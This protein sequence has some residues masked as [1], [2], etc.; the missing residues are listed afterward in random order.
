MNGAGGQVAKVC[1]QHARVLDLTPDGSRFSQ[2]MIH[3]LK[4]EM[5]IFVRVRNKFRWHFV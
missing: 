1:T 5:Y 4:K 3:M 2:L